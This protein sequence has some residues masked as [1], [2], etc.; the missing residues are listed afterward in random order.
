MQVWTFS[1]A[2]LPD[3]LQW[4]FLLLRYKDCRCWRTQQNEACSVKNNRNLERFSPS[5][6][7]VAEEKGWACDSQDLDS[8]PA[9]L[10]VGSRDPGY[11]LQAGTG[12]ALIRDPAA[13][14]A[15]HRSWYQESIPGFPSLEYCVLLELEYRNPQRLLKGCT[16]LNGAR[17]YSRPGELWQGRRQD[18]SEHVLECSHN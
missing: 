8:R 15:F 14:T 2:A 16:G 6:P 18:S 12:S 5:F 10:L 9:L 11:L 3:L 17:R 13:M 4:K 1:L 7:E